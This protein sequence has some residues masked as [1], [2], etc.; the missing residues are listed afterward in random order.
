MKIKEKTIK[1]LYGIVAL[2]AII[3]LFYIAGLYQQY[4]I[5]DKQFVVRFIALILSFIYSA[6]QAGAFDISIVKKN[7]KP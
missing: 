7:E 1:C 2:L 3:A 5:S 6:G 4:L